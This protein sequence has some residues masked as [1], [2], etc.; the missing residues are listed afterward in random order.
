MEYLKLS[1][2][3]ILLILLISSC[4]NTEFDIGETITISGNIEKCDDVR[5][6][7]L[8]K[9][10]LLA[11]NNETYLIEIDSLGNFKYEL[12]VEFPQN[13]QLALKKPNTDEILT[14]QNI[15]KDSGED[16]IQQRIDNK[17]LINFFAFP[18]DGIDI[19]ITDIIKIEYKDTVHQQISKHLMFFE[20]KMNQIENI[21][22][23]PELLQKVPPKKYY[24]LIDSIRFTL[25]GFLDQYILINKIKDPFF[26]EIAYRD[27]DFFL[28]SRLLNYA[29]I[30]K[31]ILKK[32]IS[33]PIDFFNLLDSVKH[34]FSSIYLSNYSEKFFNVPKPNE[35][36]KNFDNGISSLLEQPKSLYRDISISKLIFRFLENKDYYEVKPWME[37]YNDKTSIELFK[38]DLN[39]K[40]RYTHK[41]LT[42]PK[43]EKSILSDLSK[44]IET[45]I[46]SEII[47]KNTGKVLYIKFWNPGCGPCIEQIKFTKILEG[48][49]SNSA[50]AVIYICTPWAKDKWKATIA[51]KEIS[52]QHYLLNSEQYNNIKVM[53]Q[54][55]G[56]PHY[57]LINKQGEIVNKDAPIPGSNMIG[58][59]NSELVS[60]IS[61]LIE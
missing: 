36:Y 40:F 3:A 50:F 5:S 39:K 15:Q 53:F 45:N 20:K 55:Q 33:Y 43:I 48:K 17:L 34:D 19:H 37:I 46:L 25:T 10:N 16:E 35:E 2:I 8:S 1:R 51:K 13:I 23:T 4:K 27:I 24:H 18:C 42:N 31:Y 41:L 49:F 9:Y 7:V 47:E 32:E 30:N 57:L 59:L 61:K 21:Q 11:D 28:A 54:I 14:F 38:N 26:I 29:A 52:G 44:R 60:Q 56:I 58:S 6:I 12:K 22:I